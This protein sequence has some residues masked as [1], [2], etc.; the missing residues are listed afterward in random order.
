MT[1]L[2]AFSSS[3]I[4]LCVCLFVLCAC[5]FRVIL[6][7]GER[8]E[9]RKSRPSLHRHEHSNQVRT[10]ASYE[11]LYTNFYDGEKSGRAER[12]VRFQ[13]YQ[14][15]SSRYPISFLLFFRY[16]YCFEKRI[17]VLYHVSGFHVHLDVDLRHFS[18]VKRNL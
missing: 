11:D 4:S 18:F 3:S 15:R 16:I 1:L 8:C 2:T 17:Y 12:N 9:C 13:H 10:T 6:T 14:C 7:R 5:D